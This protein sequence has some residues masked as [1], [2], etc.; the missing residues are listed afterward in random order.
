MT[1]AA[2]SSQDVSMARMT[3]S[4]GGA[5]DVGVTISARRREYRVGKRGWQ[6]WQ[7]CGWG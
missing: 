2:V 7:V 4:E 1:A 5:S 3:G 6:S